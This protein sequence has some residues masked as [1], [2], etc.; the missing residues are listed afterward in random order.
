MP[1]ERPSDRIESLLRQLDATLN[2]EGLG[3]D[4]RRNVRALLQAWLARLDVVPREEFD[5]Q[6]AVLENT[7]R[8][9]EALEQELARLSKG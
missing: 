7:R 1:T 3:D 5:A 9:L 8:K 2:N 6:V 4:M